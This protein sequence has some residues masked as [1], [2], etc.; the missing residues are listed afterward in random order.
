MLQNDP[1]GVWYYGRYLPAD[2]E[3]KSLKKV[4]KSHQSYAGQNN[5]FARGTFPNITFQIR[6]CGHAR[7]KLEGRGT[8]SRL[9]IQQRIN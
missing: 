5:I 4:A 3:I 6:I 1:K 2:R 8:F 7:A 9:E